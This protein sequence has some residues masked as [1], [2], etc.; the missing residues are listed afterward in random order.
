M[1]S[2]AENRGMDKEEITMSLSEQNVLIVG[3]LLGSDLTTGV[4]LKIDR[5][6]ALI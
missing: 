6:H 3:F 4:V 2:G 1:K 5:G